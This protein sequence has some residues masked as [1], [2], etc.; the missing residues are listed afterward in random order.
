MYK[1]IRPKSYDGLTHGLQTM[2]P[3]EDF[4]IEILNFWAWVDKLSRQTNWADKFWSIFS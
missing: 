4:F 1:S 2:N 3:D